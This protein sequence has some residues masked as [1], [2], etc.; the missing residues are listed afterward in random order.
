MRDELTGIPCPL[1]E[2]TFAGGARVCVRRAEPHTLAAMSQSS[3]APF[4]LLRT[5]EEIFKALL[6]EIERARHSIRLESYIYCDD[7]AGRDVLMALLEAR[8]RGVN[9]RVLVD[10]FGCFE[11]NS[12]YFRP[13][14]EAGAEVRWFNALQLD[15]FAFR[16]HRKLLVCDERIAFIGSYN[17][18]QENSGDGR[19]AGWCD[20]G[21]Q[22]DAMLVDELAASF[23]EMWA[24]AEF[25]HKLFTQLRKSRAKQR[26]VG[27]R[28][29]LLL[30]GPGRGFNPLK[31]ALKRDFANA[32]EIL[33]VAAYFFPPV[34]MRR[35]LMRAARNGRRVQLLL[36]GKSDVP[37][38]QRATR[39]LYR[40]FLKAGIEIYEYEPQI[41]HAKMVIADQAV[42]MGSSNLDPRSLDFNYELMVR[43]EN[44][45]LTSDARDYFA[46]L[47]RDSRRITM[48]SWSKAQSIWER[49][50]QRWA[51]FIV[52]QFD[53]FVSQRQLRRLR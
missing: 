35:R 8:G 30:S 25:R 48:E 42:Y 33:I 49:L 9:V 20:I 32:R 47:L 40:R 46:A 50:R 37:L 13:L 52:A 44:Q 16:N 27:T 22:I 10:S 18:A 53:Q 24:L 43:A 23:D 39:S 38:S 26:R 29:E 34:R 14:I 15:R 12:D 5:G 17:I 4:Q 36:A 41:L 11:L 45:H 21:L 19:T 28:C 6:G 51:Y 7:S 31:R 3:R 2:K 1:R